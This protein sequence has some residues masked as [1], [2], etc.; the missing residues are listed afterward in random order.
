K[1]PT[2]LSQFAPR[3]IPHEKPNTPPRR[4]AT[5]PGDFISPRPTNAAVKKSSA[6]YNSMG[7]TSPRWRGR[8]AKDGFKCSG[9]S[10]VTALMQGSFAAEL[11]VSGRSGR[12]SAAP[13][14]E[15]TLD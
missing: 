1:K 13:G 2:C 7:G 12:S 4:P 11:P 3:P 15:D 8:S 14:L 5:K 10:S 9:G 6:Y